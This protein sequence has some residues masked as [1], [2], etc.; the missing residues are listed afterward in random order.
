MQRDF[1]TKLT[2]Q[3]NVYS[4]DLMGD[5]HIY[6]WAREDFLALG[7]SS[8][9]AVKAGAVKN[10]M[11]KIFRSPPCWDMH[12]KLRELSWLRSE[13]E[14]Q[15]FSHRWAHLLGEK[16][17][18]KL[19]LILDDLSQSRADGA[20]K[21]LVRLPSQTVSDESSPD[22]VE[23]VLI[24]ERGRLTVCVSSQV[25]CAQG[26]RFCQTGRM[27]LRRNLLASEIVAQVLLANEIW[28]LLMSA[29]EA[30]EGLQRRLSHGN[31]R[32]TN[33]VFMGMGE[34]LDNVKE[35]LQA[36]RVLSDPWGLGIGAKKIT[37]STVGL[38][39]ELREVLTTSPFHVALS[40]HNPLPEERTRLMPVNARYPLAEVISCL[41]R[42][43]RPKDEIFIQYTV[44]RGVNDSPMHAEKLIEIL[45]GLACKVNL[46]PLNEHEGTR[47]R[48]PGL[49]TLEIFRNQLRAA[50]LVVTLR[51]SKGRDI[52]A[53]CGQLVSLS[54][55]T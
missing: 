43:A 14:P 1:D 12:P 22:R 18:G 15:S 8:S 11:A 48:R 49:D 13:Q 38:V 21:L 34:P 44:I 32:V 47:Y 30:A 52:A 33:V 31:S 23:T 35:V 51:L 26:C 3:D 46:I 19:P 25:G 20:L 17:W 4:S 55:S 39:P 10:L 50:G 36:S 16:K 40:V 27:G 41:R 5:S 7:R 9:R 2:S 37:I 45:K 42:F 6:G 24:P 53:A 54:E 28:R 29:R